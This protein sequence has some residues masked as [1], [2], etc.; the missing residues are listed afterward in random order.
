MLCC[1]LT[2]TGHPSNFSY[3]ASLVR[4]NVVLHWFHYSAI[5]IL[6]PP[7]W[8][9]IH[10][11]IAKSTMPSICKCSWNILVTFCWFQLAKRVDRCQSWWKTNLNSWTV[12]QVFVWR[13]H[14]LL[15]T[16]CDGVLLWCESFLKIP[17]NICKSTLWHQNDIVFAWYDFLLVKCKHASAKNI[18]INSHVFLYVRF[19]DCASQVYLC[20]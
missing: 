11:T 17:R 12:R 20:I 8:C 19:L 2:N 10:A 1:I 6:R 16:S 5:V 9:I 4:V 14:F 18:S 15:Y 3:C 13:R 7:T